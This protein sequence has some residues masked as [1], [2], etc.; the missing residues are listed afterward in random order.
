[1]PSQQCFSNFPHRYSCQ[2][3]LPKV[4]FDTTYDLW[5][6]SINLPWLKR[7]SLQISLVS[8]MKFPFDYA[9]KHKSQ[10][11]FFLRVYKLC[12]PSLKN[13]CKNSYD[14]QKA[15]NL[16]PFRI[17]SFRFNFFKC[18]SSNVLEKCNGKSKS[19]CCEK[20]LNCKFHSIIVKI[21]WCYPITFTQFW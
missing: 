13:D 15:S 19:N 20:R 21:A 17:Q 11:S 12:C 6:V 18:F 1:M 9:W 4:I 5:A 2:F 10:D 3:K 16:T 14:L 8:C 7:M